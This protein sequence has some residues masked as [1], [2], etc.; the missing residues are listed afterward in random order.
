ELA[1]RAG[2]RVTIHAGEADGPSSIADALDCGA[3]RIGHGVRLVEDIDGETFGPVAERVR[4]ERICLEV[5]PSSNLQTGTAADIPA[6]P[7]GRLHDLGFALAVSSDNRLM[8]RT[9]TSRELALTAEAHGWGLQALETIALTGLEAGFAPQET[10]RVLR[11]EVVLPAFRA[12]R[13]R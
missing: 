12:A 7:V 2:V 3:E 11:E 4:R 1:R 9:R 5:C 10:R 8:S 6:H 13:T